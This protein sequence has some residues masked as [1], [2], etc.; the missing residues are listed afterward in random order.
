L[1]LNNRCLWDAHLGSLFKERIS[2]CYSKN[3]LTCLLSLE[4]CLTNCFDFPLLLYDHNS[5]NS[6]SIVRVLQ[7]VSS[8]GA[9][10]FIKDCLY[11]TDDLGLRIA[12][13]VI[14]WVVCNIRFAVLSLREPAV[15][16][17]REP[18]WFSLWIENL[19]VNNWFTCA[20]IHTTEL[21]L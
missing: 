15:L 11:L 6:N 13:A 21:R 20:V 14:H 4:L 2:L 8:S 10:L 9:L 3:H 17:L 5:C 18:T 1:E 7:K 19:L 12:K 16:S